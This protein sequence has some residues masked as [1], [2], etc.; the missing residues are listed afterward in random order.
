MKL[1][2]H[3]VIFGGVSVVLFFCSIFF[4]KQHAYALSPKSKSCE[5]VTLEEQTVR[6]DSPKSKS[7]VTEDTGPVKATSLSFYL[8]KFIQESP[9]WLLL[10]KKKKSFSFFVPTKIMVIEKKSISGISCSSKVEINVK[11]EEY[12]AKT[13]QEKK[14]SWLVL[15]K[16]HERRVIKKPLRDICSPISLSKDIRQPNDSELFV[17]GFILKIDN[18]EY[19]KLLQ[20]T[21]KTNTL[22]DLVTSLRIDT[23]TART[24]NN[25]TFLNFRDENEIEAEEADIKVGRAVGA[26]LGTILGLQILPKYLF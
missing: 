20:Q 10:G 11:G 25:Y 13:I 12:A 16:T 9:I 26:L 4:Q 17:E 22:Q 6:E 2:K 5:V 24:L 8:D 14:I 21:Y 19:A 23:E 18:E 15:P 3:L 1:F 7:C